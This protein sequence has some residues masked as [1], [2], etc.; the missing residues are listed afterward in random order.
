MSEERWRLLQDG[1]PVAWA[2]GARAANEIAH[3]ALVYSSDGPVEIQY[4]HNGRW[5]RATKEHASVVR[6]IVCKEP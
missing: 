3:Y 4:R 1:V 5:K 6:G 2:D